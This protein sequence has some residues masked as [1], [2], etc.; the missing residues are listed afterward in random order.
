MQGVLTA[1]VAVAGT[2]LGAVLTYLF[3]RR[4]LEKTQEV[5]RREQLRQERLSAF[6]AF[7]A[8]AMDLRRAERDRWNLRKEGRED[9]ERR[10]AR[11]AT[12]HLRTEA[13]AAFFRMKLISE[14]GTDDRLM[15]QAEKVIEVASSVSKA[16]NEED[17]HARGALTRTV[18]DEFVKAASS[19]VRL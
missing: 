14:P 11:Q 12:Y 18:L 13:W 5:A 3:Q 7:A 1:G 16:N 6:E 15:E 9:A 8:T 4:T 2:L 17:Y 10:E 19:R